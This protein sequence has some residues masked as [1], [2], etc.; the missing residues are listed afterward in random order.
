MLKFLL[1]MLYLTY[2]QAESVGTIR[3]RI[4]HRFR[5]TAV[6][7]ARVSDENAT[8]TA[9]DQRDIDCQHTSHQIES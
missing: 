8:Q 6:D 4:Q 9:F 5:A 7:S 3:I 2:I 1:K